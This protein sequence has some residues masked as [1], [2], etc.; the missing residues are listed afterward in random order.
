[1]YN[2]ATDTTTTHV[3]AY[4]VHTNKATYGNIQAFYYSAPTSWVIESPPGVSNIFTDNTGSM[5][6]I[7][8]GHQIFVHYNKPTTYKA[9]I[10]RIYQEHYPYA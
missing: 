7:A 5:S 6:A 8:T 4:N 3:L 10:R 1:M 9:M 2:Y